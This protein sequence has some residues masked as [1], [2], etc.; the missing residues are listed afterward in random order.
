MSRAMLDSAALCAV[1]IAHN[2]FGQSRFAVTA[3]HPER[4]AHLRAVE[5]GWL[6]EPLD[7]WLAITPDGV[8]ALAPYRHERPAE[9]PP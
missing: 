8:A 5:L 2:R 7:G 1:S 6:W 4:E 9:A 3:R